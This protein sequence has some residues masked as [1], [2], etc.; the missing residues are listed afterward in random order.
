M[1]DN[2]KDNKNKNDG[3]KKRKNPWASDKDSGPT[4]GAGNT[5]KSAKP[6]P[7]GGQ[8]PQNVYSLKEAQDKIKG[9]LPP[10]V[11][12]NMKGPKLFLVGLAALILLWLAS[13]LY[14]LQ[15]S[16][17]AVV[18]QFGQFHK[19]VEEPGLK[20]HLPWP[21]QTVE[22][23]NVTNER[24]IEVGFRSYTSRSGN[25]TGNDVSDESL[26]LTGDENIIDIDFVVLWRVGNAANY[27]FKIRDPDATIKIVAESAMREIIGQTKIQPALTEART[28]IQVSTKELMQKMLDEYEAGVT[29]NNVQ[30]QK[31]DPPASVIDAFNDVQRARQ[32]KEELRNKAEAYRNDII[33]RARGQAEKLRQEAEAYR[34]QIVNRAKGDA[35]RFTSVYEAY[36]LGPRVTT[37]RIYLETL[38]DVLKNANTIILDSQKSG[39]SVPYLNLNE[40][41]NKP[42]A[43]Q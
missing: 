28:Q 26:M 42:S 40:L 24:R 39:G 6:N 4:K 25:S 22:V 19:S 34:S 10:S 13:G 32:E 2:D 27:L 30:L 16:E 37:E 18:L 17:N 31:V 5:P 7:F 41:R 8:S 20:W 21:V 3:S 33:P 29:I 35:D 15:P 43:S 38:E 11:G 12:D 36:K 9:M 23:V 1:S 14:F